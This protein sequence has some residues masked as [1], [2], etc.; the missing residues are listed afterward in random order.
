M[1]QLTSKFEWMSV[2][3]SCPPSSQLVAKCSYCSSS[4][5]F[6]I[7][8][9]LT[10][11]KIVNRFSSAKNK[12]FLEPITSLLLQVTICSKI[13]NCQK[14]LFCAVACKIELKLKSLED[15]WHMTLQVSMIKR[16]LCPSTDV[17]IIFSCFLTL[18][19]V[20]HRFPWDLVGGLLV[21]IFNCCRIEVTNLITMQCCCLDFLKYIFGHLITLWF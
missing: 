4:I 9:G 2:I 15:E 17:C 13:L 7:S 5:H 10:T 1:K 21:K 3:I 18:D 12:I 16:S 20:T 8:Q 19:L 14:Y 11:C 6:Y